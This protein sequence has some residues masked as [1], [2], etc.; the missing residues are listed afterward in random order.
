VIKGTDVRLLW[1]TDVHIGDRSPVSRA[2]DWKLVCLDKLRQVGKIAKDV[3]AAAVLDGGDFFH[4][5]SPSR[6]SHKLVAS[7]AALHAKYPCPVYANVG[8][9]DCVY[10]DYSYLGQQ[11]LGVMYDTGSI[12]RLYD[13]HQGVFTAPGTQVRVVGIPYHGTVYDWERFE[14]AAS[15]RQ[16]GDTHLIVVGHVLASKAGGKMFEGEDIIKYSDLAKLEGVDAWCFGHWHKDQGI[17][18]LA[19]GALV[20][21]T[22]SLTRGTL[23]QDDL[24]RKPC[25]VELVCAGDG[26]VTANRHNLVVAAPEEC[27]DLDRREAVQAREVA[28]GGFVQSLQSA[29][30]G[31]GNSDS[32]L[33]TVRALSIEPRLRERAI[34]YLEGVG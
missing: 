26:T 13:E 21:N 3:G 28:V 27:F 8:N 34:V 5:K 32:L 33:D 1:R 20:V 24:A 16:P 29:L 15:S 12:Q 7:V 2:D 17:T 31:S 9:H 25:T 11:P 14:K 30:V 19:N 4:I 22:G 10:G 23:S 6:N 18:T